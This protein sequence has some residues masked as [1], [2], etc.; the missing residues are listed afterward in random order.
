DK[1]D[2]DHYAQAAEQVTLVDTV[3]YENLKPG[4]E[5][6]MTGTL[7][8]KSTGKALTDSDGNEITAS[9]TFTP[10]SKTGEVELEFTFDGSLLAGE[11]IVAFESLVSD[12]IE[13]AAHADID[14]EGQTVR[15]LGIHT[16]ATDKADGDKLVTGSEVVISDEVAYEGLTAGQEYTLT[17]TLM[18]A[19][20]GEA[21][22]DGEGLFAKAVTAS[23]T[24]TPEEA[25]GIQVVDLSMDSKD[26]GGHKLVVFEKLSLDGKQ[27]A[28]HEDPSDEGQTVTVVEIGTT[29][30]DASD[31]DHVIVSGKVKLTDTI[32]YKGLVPGETYTAHGTLIVKSTGMPLEDA[33]GKPVTATAEFTPDKAD[34]TAE[35]TFE[36]DA[37]KI[38]EGVEL[39]AFEECL[40]VNGNVVAVHQ[41]IDDEGQ[42]VVVDNPETPEVPDEPGKGYD[43]TGVDTTVLFAAVIVLIA[44]GAAFGIYAIRK[45]KQ[46]TVESDE[47][48]DSENNES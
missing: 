33:D 41:D 42:T 19:E 44:A 13:V 16:T 14:D 1:A 6:T 37:S 45:R 18:D 7:M 10:K 9:K 40:D 24:F 15:I 47:D 17:A 48:D 46:A 34:G 43:K 32:E 27:V 3:Y 20:T 12:G 26:L 25:D 21:V 36:F 29:L 2:G 28:S 22:M 38:E 11:D 23:V 35:V 5:Y 39:V 31:G 30:V 4:T 8:V